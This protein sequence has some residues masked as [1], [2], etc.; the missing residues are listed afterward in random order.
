MATP[1]PGTPGI[2]AALRRLGDGLISIVQG[3]LDL[4]SLEL[5][6]EKYRLIQIVFWISAVVFSGVM[7]IT[8]GSLAVV[9]LFWPGARLAVLGGLAGLYTGAFFLIAIR[10]R[11]YLKEQPRPF[12][13]TL[14]ELQDDRT[15]IRKES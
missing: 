8:F 15:C 14:E 3:R 10:F 2:F 13:A 9:Y 1:A 4:F 11:R 6:E 12:A 5:Q 7:A